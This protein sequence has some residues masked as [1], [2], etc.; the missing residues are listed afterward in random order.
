M[1]PISRRGFV[2]SL[3]ASSLTL[4]LVS[5][6]CTHPPTRAD[7]LA[8]MVQRQ[9]V[10]DLQAIVRESQALDAAVAL[11]VHSDTAEAL[12]T[13]RAALKSSIL[14]WS[15]AYAFRRG[16]IVDSHALLRATFWPPRRGPIVELIAGQQVIDDKLVDSLG[17]DLKG[18]FALELLL[19]AQPLP[20]EPAWLEGALRKRTLAL[21]GALTRDVRAQAERARAA[22]GDG[23]R[24]A[25]EFAEAG[26]TSLS[27]IVNDMLVTV[28]TVIGARMEPVLNMQRSGQLD[29]A[30]VQ[31]AL[32]G[33]STAIPRSWLAA[34]QAQYVHDRDGLSA[35]V[36]P[37]SPEVDQRLRASF[38][39]S[40]AAFPQA[41]SSLA[42]WV[43]AQP[44][45]YERGMRVIKD[46]EVAL[47]ADL[48]SVLGVTLTFTSTDGD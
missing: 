38:R 22:L 44:A 33:L 43:A 47:K 28:E 12:T 36:A 46:L 11:L 27:Q 2:A 17:V 37:L 16:P 18:V 29:S 1:S 32:S 25:R 10:P 6:G 8:A 42:Q 21:L 14:A 30:Q 7:V 20:T 45:E 34:L 4:P 31:G 26:Q 24:F 19:F 35:L 48:A 39:S 3:A 13:A 23:R 5:W 15:Q 41:N 9:A 40:L